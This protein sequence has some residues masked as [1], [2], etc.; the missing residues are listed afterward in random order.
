[1]AGYLLKYPFY[2]FM[3]VLVTTCTKVWFPVMEAFGGRP[4]LED[5]SLG[6]FE[7]YI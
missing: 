6:T 5:S 2:K 1:M 3:F 4:F 7:I